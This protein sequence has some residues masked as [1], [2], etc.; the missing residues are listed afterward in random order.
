M[1]NYFDT[2]IINFKEVVDIWK[3]YKLT[4]KS[5]DYLIHN[6]TEGE[7][8]MLLSN[9]YYNNINDWWI[10]YLFNNMYDANFS[11]IQS[12]VINS[13]INKYIGM[14]YS[15]ST[16]NTKNKNI[17]KFH[18]RSFYLESYDLKTSITKTNNLLT[19]KSA[20]EIEKFKEYIQTKLIYDSFYNKPLKIPNSELVKVIKNTF[21][22]F[23]KNWK[24]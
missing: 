7:N 16:L 13:T 3:K 21:Q 23:S 4:I 19:S 17:I 20:V 2:E 24:K 11:L 5:E 9:T 14:I 1:F 12:N 15:Y 10:I 6:L 8:L 18:I 22:T